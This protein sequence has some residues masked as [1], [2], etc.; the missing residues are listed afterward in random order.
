MAATKSP[1]EVSED[2]E[3]GHLA[4]FEAPKGVEGKAECK[5]GKSPDKRASVR[6]W[7]RE[8]TEPPLALPE[9]LISTLTR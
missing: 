6:L 7:C 9:K 1:G 2:T 5:P 8:V 3:A 4:A